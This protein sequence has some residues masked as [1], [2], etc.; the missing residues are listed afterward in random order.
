M[1]IISNK[2]GIC[3]LWKYDKLATEDASSVKYEIWA[4]SAEKEKVSRSC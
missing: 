4:H 2:S 1:C 3:K